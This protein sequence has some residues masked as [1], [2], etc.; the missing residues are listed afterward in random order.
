MIKQKLRK[1]I[2]FAVL[3]LCVC[4]VMPCYRQQGPVEENGVLRV[5]LVIKGLSRLLRRE[6]FHPYRVEGI[7][8]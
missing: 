6:Y 7:S 3:V 8:T 2:G 4:M 5:N 1:L